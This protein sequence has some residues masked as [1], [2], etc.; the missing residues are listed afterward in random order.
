MTVSS[1]GKEGGELLVL[2]VLVCSEICA[3][4]SIESQQYAFSSTRREQ[5][6]YIRWKRQFGAF[7]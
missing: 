1:D 6:G 7:V 5:V 4:G 3:S 2:G